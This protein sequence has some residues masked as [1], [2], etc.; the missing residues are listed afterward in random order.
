MTTGTGRFG[1]ALRRSAAQKD[2]TIPQGRFLENL[3]QVSSLHNTPDVVKYLSAVNSAGNDKIAAGYLSRPKVWNIVVAT[4]FQPPADAPFHAQPNRIRNFADL[5]ELLGEI[6]QA[7]VF[8]K[9][10][11]PPVPDEITA[12]LT[13]T[14]AM[15]PVS[16]GAGG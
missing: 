9:L 6:R 8:H 16:Q 1:D 10:E 3:P 13:R 15:R 11:L 4:N 5:G 14:D 2:G 12:L 7:F